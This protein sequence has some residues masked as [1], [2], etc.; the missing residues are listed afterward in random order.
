MAHGFHKARRAGRCVS[1]R[2][3]AALCRC[4]KV[5]QLPLWPFLFWRNVAFTLF[6]GSALQKTLQAHT[7]LHPY[8]RLA[9]ECRNCINHAIWSLRGPMIGLSGDEQHNGG[10]LLIIR[11]LHLPRYMQERS[12]RRHF[13]RF[14]ILVL[15]PFT[16]LSPR[17]SQVVFSRAA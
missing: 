8:I 13:F 12:R 15:R 17:L 5:N 14:L 4:L 7:N 3:S 10:P 11:K 2:P 6:P 16:Y 1:L 9:Q